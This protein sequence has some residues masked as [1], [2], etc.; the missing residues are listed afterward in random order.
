MAQRIALGFLLEKIL[1]EATVNINEEHK[2]K[3]EKD[4]DNKLISI[5][6]SDWSRLPV[7]G[8]RMMV[9]IF[10]LNVVLLPFGIVPA[11]LIEIA[12]SKS[13]EYDVEDRFVQLLQNAKLSREDSKE[14]LKEMLDYA[15][16]A[17]KNVRGKLDIFSDEAGEAVSRMFTKSKDIF[18]K[19]GQRNKTDK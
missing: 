3:I 13:K 16:E 9:M 15:G 11:T 10:A 18:G 1:K 14:K 19:I 17:G 4:V 8:P 2:S 5:F 7:T 12:I 6:G